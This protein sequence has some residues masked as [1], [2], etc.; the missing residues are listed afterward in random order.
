MRPFY[1]THKLIMPNCKPAKSRL[2]GKACVGWTRVCRKDPTAN[3]KVNVKAAKAVKT[4]VK[5]KAAKAVKAGVKVK[6]AKA[7]KAGVKVKTAK[8]PRC[9][10]SKPCG[11]ACIPVTRICHKD[12]NGKAVKRNGKAGVKAGAKRGKRATKHPGN[13]K[14]FWEGFGVKVNPKD[15]AALH[16]AAKAKEEAYWSQY[17]YVTKPGH[18]VI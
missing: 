13:G 15:V 3:A 5:V 4:G 9:P 8:G 17:P 16:A 6:A 7:V 12:G 10:N 2:C 11:K 1:R 18:F 14:D